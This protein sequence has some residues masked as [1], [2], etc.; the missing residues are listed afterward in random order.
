MPNL[1]NL[2][3]PVCFVGVAFG[4]YQ[5]L[6]KE[7]KSP[8]EPERDSDT[9]AF[10]VTSLGDAIFGRTFSRMAER[11]P[12]CLDSGDF[13]AMMADCLCMETASEVV[14]NSGLGY[15]FEYRAYKYLDAII[16]LDVFDYKPLGKILSADFHRPINMTR[17]LETV[18]INVIVRSWPD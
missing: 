6:Q 16:Y 10:A 11:Y 5:T 17:L 8:V 7:S 1:S 4:C 14:V 9:R 2:R 15:W 3:L 12:D 13:N 18:K